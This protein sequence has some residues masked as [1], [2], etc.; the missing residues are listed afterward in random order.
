MIPS[1]SCF[2]SN[3]THGSQMA[4]GRSTNPTAFKLPVA[5]SS[6]HEKCISASVKA[7]QASFNAAPSD[8]TYSMKEYRN[9][10]QV[11]QNKI[12]TENVNKERSA[13]KRW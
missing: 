11:V 9:C 7:Y 10:N 3:L 4:A 13:A 6:Y 8:Q 2:H 12:W 5:S 1:H